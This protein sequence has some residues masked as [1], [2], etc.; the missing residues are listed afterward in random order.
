MSRLF[1]LGALLLLTGCW[2]SGPWY[3]SSDNRPAIPDGRY[4]LM[5]A[6][7]PGE[8]DVLTIRRRPDG[9]TAIEGGDQALSA[10]MLPLG[11]AP[12]RHILQ[13]QREDGV[14][15]GALYMLLDTDKGRYRLAL[16][17][18]S[19]PWAKAAEASGGSIVRDPQSAATCTFATQ[20][21]LLAALTAI[22]KNARFD[23]DLIPEA[24]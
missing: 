23:F 4:R 13:L 7:M 20:K 15:R 5:A 18:C 22:S 3:T 9:A 1:L 2:T 10:I 11:K 8:G 14:A 24:P 21:A 6:E 12:H 19:G 16:L 17:P